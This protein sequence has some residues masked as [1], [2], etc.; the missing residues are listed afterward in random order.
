MRTVVQ[1]QQQPIVGAGQIDQPRDTPPLTPRVQ[2]RVAGIAGPEPP[3]GRREHHPAVANP[4]QERH[5]G[6][7]PPVEGREVRRTVRRQLQQR[8]A[9]RRSGRRIQHVPGGEDQWPIDRVPPHL[10]S[11]VDQPDRQL[12]H[13]HHPIR[14][15]RRR[16]PDRQFVVAHQRS[17]G[18]IGR[19]RPQRP[20]DQLSHHGISSAYGGL[21]GNHLRQ[22]VAR[23][24]AEQVGEAA[25]PSSRLRRTEVRPDHQQV[26]APV[27]RRPAAGCDED[28]Q[29]DRHR[30]VLGLHTVRHPLD[31]HV[32]EDDLVA[33][34]ADRSGREVP[35]YLRSMVGGRA[36]VAGVRGRRTE[37][38]PRIEQLE[39]GHAA[40][41]AVPVVEGRAVAGQRRPV[42]VRVQSEEDIDGA[43][44]LVGDCCRDPCPD[45]GKTGVHLHVGARGRRRIA[46]RAQERPRVPECCGCRARGDE[47]NVAAGRGDLCQ[48]PG[49]VAG[50]RGHDA[51]EASQRVTDERRQQRGQQE[52]LFGQLVEQ[53]VD[54]PGGRGRAFG[55]NA[56]AQFANSDRTPPGQ[57]ESSTYHRCCAHRHIGPGSD[58]ARAGVR[59]VDPAGVLEGTGVGVH[60]Q[61]RIPAHLTDHLRQ[62]LHVRP[63]AGRPSDR[64]D[65]EVGALR[66]AC[67][68]DRGEATERRRS[69]RRTDQIPLQRGL[70]RSG[71][72]GRGRGQGSGQVRRGDRHRELD[73]GIGP[74][75]LDVEL[76]A[77][78]G[79]GRC[80]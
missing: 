47:V 57:R 66:P 69:G 64:I 12:V 15:E 6:H 65:L 79:E 70:C 24:R 8:P 48:P 27:D 61:L 25:E 22:Q 32:V 30:Q 13:L 18:D 39:E 40:V 44:D 11:P 37:A 77:E 46:A 78:V 35:Q 56:S 23:V 20:V 55:E 68:A 76:L 26:V 53:L 41:V 17:Y 5:P 51:H 52:L 16:H 73:L 29:L 38:E 80:R 21:R 49:A 72:L 50:H 2:P 10:E 19:P 14:R 54:L 7:R 43:G 3:L 59:E 74:P 45:Q 75:P 62:P 67:D 60:A 28:A 71:G 4:W 9:D 34:V 42:G 31:Q 58:A 63:R 1:I 36:V 33:A